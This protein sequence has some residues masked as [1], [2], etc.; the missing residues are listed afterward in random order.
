MAFHMARNAASLD[1]RR[2]SNHDVWFND[3]LSSKD[4]TTLP[5]TLDHST[6]RDARELFRPRNIGPCDLMGW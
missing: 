1:A 3:W 4:A 5:A 6:W 2:S